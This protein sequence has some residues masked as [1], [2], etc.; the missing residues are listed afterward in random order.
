MEVFL[1]I[2]FAFLEILLEVA[3]E[4]AGETLMD[5]MGR[6][7]VE[8]FEIPEFRNP[9]VAGVG[10][11]LLGGIGGGLSVL[12]FPHPLVHPSR[13]HGVSL[14]ISPVITGL[15]MSFVGSVLRRRSIRTLRIETFAYGFVF[16][17]GMA[18]V[19]LLFAK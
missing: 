3:V 6:V 2:L 7:L 17:F 15:V 13:I 8:L 1:E 12:I 5:I 14:L 16:A 19:R 9:A 18:L 4:L 11:L 10:Y